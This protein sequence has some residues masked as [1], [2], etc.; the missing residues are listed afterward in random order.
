MPS[1]LQHVPVSLFI[2]RIFAK[3][4][5]KK[6]I[7]TSLFAQKNRTATKQKKYICCCLGFNIYFLFLYPAKR[8]F[9]ISLELS[10]LPPK[11]ERRKNKTNE[12]KSHARVHLLPLSCAQNKKTP[13]KKTF[14]TCISTGNDDAYSLSPEISKFDEEPFFFYGFKKC[15]KK[16]LKKN[17]SPLTHTHNGHVP[18]FGVAPQTHCCVK[19]NIKKPS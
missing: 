6:R 16:K 1:T 15:K 13:P 12:S 17:R 14:S 11:K 7:C 19:Q 10:A 8:F 18:G 3:N 5:N 2:F 9:I 4:K